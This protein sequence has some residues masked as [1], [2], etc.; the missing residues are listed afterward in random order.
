MKTNRRS[1]VAGVAGAVA[2]S[3]VAL[4]KASSPATQKKNVLFLAVDDLRTCLGC[5]GDTYAKTPNID[6]LAKRG[7]LF[8]RAYCQEAVCN[9]S[10]QSLMTGRRPDTIRVWDLK[11]HFRNTTPGVKTVAE[12]FRDHG[13][14]AQS[15]GKI[16]HGEAPMADPQ[17]WSVPEQFEYTPKQDDYQLERNHL[18]RT[19]GKAD[20][21]E[22]VV[23]PDDAYPDGEVAKGAVEALHQFAKDPSKPFFL[24]VG[25]RKPHLPFTAPKKYWD[26]FEGLE[27]PPIQQID[28][29]EG[30]PELALHNSVELRGYLGIPAEGPIPP[31][32]AARLRRGYY[33]SLAYTDAQFGRVLRALE[34]TGLAE[35][36][37]I[38]FWVDH[39]YHLGEHGLWCKTT[40]Y[41]LDT[42]VP[43]IF[44][45]P[46]SKQRGKR[47]RATVELLD[48]FPTLC[49]LCDVPPTEGLEGMSLRPWLENPAKGSM[50]PAFSQFPRPWFYKGQ[51]EHMGYAVRTDGHRYVEWREFATGKVTDRELYDM[52]A[53]HFIE[54]HNRAAEPA[55]ADLVQQMSAMLPK[56]TG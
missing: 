27:V 53:Q 29:P 14:F 21:D 50:K 43:L 26:M 49:D 33:A 8:E 5:Y 47:C 9:P 16:F 40:N 37:L 55:A 4:A 13:Y 39:G 35:N 36:T 38:V 23:A 45:D 3:H 42:H 15:F 56:H 46:S 20:V 52:D 54:A 1:F 30:A 44:V 10:R 12:Q 51:P 19:A 22:W 2:L 18:H 31:T 24:G 25:M 6:R 32:L 28:A 17:S 34:E 11:T 48:I 41:E 7:V